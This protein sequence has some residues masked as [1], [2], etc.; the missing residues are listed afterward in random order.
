MKKNSD[1]I[2]PLFFLDVWRNNNEEHRVELHPNSR[3]MNYKLRESLARL[4]YTMAKK[5][6][7]NERAFTRNENDE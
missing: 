5:E 6:P 4:R 3:Q 7:I 1:K 2:N